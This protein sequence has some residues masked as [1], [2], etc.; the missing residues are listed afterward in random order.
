MA[1]VYAMQFF[2]PWNVKFI[3]YHH[4]TKF[5]VSGSFILEKPFFKFSVPLKLLAFFFLLFSYK[6]K[7]TLTQQ[8]R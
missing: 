4:P 2:S 1:T 5:E 6:P 3:K 7:A 8:K